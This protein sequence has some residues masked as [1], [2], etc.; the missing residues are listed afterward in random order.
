MKT[1]LGG[2]DSGGDASDAGDSA[3]DAGEAPR[4]AG[5][6]VASLECC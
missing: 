5:S 6:V 2:G 3:G 4:A 1:K